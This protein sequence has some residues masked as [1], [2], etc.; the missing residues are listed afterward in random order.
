MFVSAAH[1]GNCA[2]AIAT[3]GYLLFLETRPLH[4]SD[5]H[6]HR[7][8]MARS[9]LK[10]GQ[11]A[12]A[13]EIASR[14][15]SA[16]PSNLDALEINVLVAI[17]RGDDRAAEEFL[18]HAI[19]TAPERRW[20][21]GD[22]IRL[23]LRLDRDP[24]A[25][26]VARSAL[27]A[28]PENPDAHAMLGS[29]FAKREQWV[30]A[31]E[32]F[33]RAISAAGDHP[34][35][36]T[37]LGQARLRSGRIHDARSLLERA[38]IADPGALEPLVYLADAEEQLG[39]LSDSERLLDRAEQLARDHGTD[40]D[41]QRSVLLARMGQPERALSLLESKS[42]IS[43]AARLHRGRLYDR[44]GRYANAWAD[45]IAG[46]AELAERKRRY[47]PAQELARSAERLGGF[48]NDLNKTLLPPAQL[49]SRVP[50]PIFVI[51]FPR[52][53]T[54]LVEQILA[55]HSAIDAGGE[56]PF[57]A[58]L[59][60]LASKMAGGEDAFPEGLINAPANWTTRL[61]DAYLAQA[62]RYG[63]FRT[64]ARYFVDKMPSN[65]FW[66]PLLRLAFPDSPV[67]L[68]CRHPLDVLTSVMAHDMTHG[69][70][71]A[72]RV[73]DAA[74]HFALVDQLVEAYR[75]GGF[76][77]TYELSYERLVADQAGETRAL[78][79]A[80]GLLMEPSQLNFQERPEVSPTPSYAQVREPLNSRSIGRWR[81]YQ[82]E[83]EVVQPILQR[84]LIRGGYT[85]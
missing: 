63:L 64:G 42:T 24:E 59:H 44:L 8:A 67:I 62:E 81:N 71:C 75:K 60:Q 47:Y 58:E 34:Q 68:V 82:A 85:G 50:Q 57:G 35:L 66:L 5:V 70:N 51:G 54:T 23:L 40:V 61:R 12:V 36:L 56:L 29:L 15:L 25:E 31:A 32:H 55:S 26:A 80:L 3:I 28:D 16:S 52:S 4:R 37:S 6:A 22:L 13:A 78:M 38:T 76:G 33:E 18:R 53:G 41:L 2:G 14:I 11:L 69:F 17:E 79:D 72:Y 73:E 84:A 48:F 74:L 39:H 65:D 46:K 9:A 10:G 43:G 20:P 19:A 7:I 30:E 77:P 27:A 45:W 49:L 83:L 1:K 21:Y